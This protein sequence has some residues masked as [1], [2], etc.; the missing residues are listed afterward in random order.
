MKKSVHSHFKYMMSIPDLNFKFYPLEDKVK[1]NTKHIGQKLKPN[2]KYQIENICKNIMIVIPA[3]FFP[4]GR[5]NAT[6]INDNI[7]IIWDADS[8]EQVRQLERHSE[9]S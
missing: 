8:G 5:Y 9:C 2:I 4:D 1:V 6:G 3:C 7:A